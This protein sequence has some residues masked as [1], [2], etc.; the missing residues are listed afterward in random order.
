[1]Q[2]PKQEGRS[3]RLSLSVLTF[4]RS[5][6][7]KSSFAW[8]CAFVGPRRAGSPAIPADTQV[9]MAEIRILSRFFRSALLPFFWGEFPS[10]IDCRRKGYP[11]SNL[12]TKRGRT[13]ED[14]P[15]DSRACAVVLVAAGLPAGAR[16]SDRCAW[17]R[18]G[19]A[20]QF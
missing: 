18:S 17:G 5:P 12:W 20:G 9:E 2:L 7:S 10:E 14:S 8:H 13:R 11:Y 4:L 1:M 15:A 19:G 6:A 3:V 16:A